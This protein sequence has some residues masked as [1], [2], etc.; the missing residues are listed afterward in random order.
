ML[1]MRNIPIQ[2]IEAPSQCMCGRA[3][4][5]VSPC[6]KSLKIKLRAK[7]VKYAERKALTQENHTKYYN[8]HKKSL[9]DFYVVKG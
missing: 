5:L 6:Q 7:D 9:R 3:L 8:Q 4:W 2:G 1:K